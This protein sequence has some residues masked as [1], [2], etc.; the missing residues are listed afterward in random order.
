ML[1]KYGNIHIW[2]TALSRAN[3]LLELL[4]LLRQHRY[5]VSGKLLAEKLGISLRTFYRDI[6]ALQSQGA[7]ISGE[8]GVGYVLKPGF[9]LPPLMFSEEEIEAIVL[10]S[11][12][13]AR[14]ADHKLQLAA[15][16]AL[17][18]ISSVLPHDLRQQLESS[19][20]LVGPANTVLS[21]DSYEA[22]IRHAIR[23]E[24]KLEI[25]YSDAKEAATTRII[26][27]L[28]LGFFE[29]TRVVIAWCEKRNDF[30]HFRSDRITS[31][32]LIETGFGKNRQAL[33]KQWRAAFNIPEQ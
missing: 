6:A 23:K 32:S 16:S 1:P 22:L 3:R 20:L 13:V 28:A 17:A 26:W 4:Q 18:K 31:L 33:L 12:W 15:A 19:G 29:S 11:R 2:Y 8:P 7:D 21:N 25:A 14:R 9:M 10:G 30:R 27:P 5:P 24:Y